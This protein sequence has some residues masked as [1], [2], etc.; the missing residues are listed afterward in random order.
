[1]ENNK[2]ISNYATK[3]KIENVK[4]SLGSVNKSINKKIIPN[5]RS[6]WTGREADAY[7]EKLELVTLEINKLLEKLDEL[8]SYIDKSNVINNSNTDNK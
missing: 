1:M 4:N 5:L 2:N 7:D 8:N 3:Q 6:A